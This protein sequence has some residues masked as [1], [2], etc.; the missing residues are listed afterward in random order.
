MTKHPRKP[1]KKIVLSLKDLNP[2]KITSELEKKLDNSASYNPKN[3]RHD[4]IR[5]NLKKHSNGRPY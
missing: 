1:Q 4:Y 5:Q 3:G 2:E